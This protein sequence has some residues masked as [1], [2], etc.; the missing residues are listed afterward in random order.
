MSRF[1][2]FMPQAGL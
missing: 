1:Y 2:K